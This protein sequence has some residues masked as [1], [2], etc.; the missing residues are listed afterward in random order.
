MRCGRK[1]QG[2]VLEKDGLRGIGVR[3]VTQSYLRCMFEINKDTAT[4][5]KGYRHVTDD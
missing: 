5:N 4:D 2:H 1:V 3:L